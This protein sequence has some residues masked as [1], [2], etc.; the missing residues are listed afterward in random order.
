MNRESKR[1]QDREERRAERAEGAISPSEP[2]S[3]RHRATPA[4][5]LREV[6]AEL[7]KVNW[8]HRQEVVNYTVVVLV[9]TL[10]L[11]LIIWGLDWIFSNAVIN[12]LE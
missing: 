12:F 11:V 2:S 6:R 3:D 7:K 4:Q 8:P 9:T 10:V 5:F 1:H